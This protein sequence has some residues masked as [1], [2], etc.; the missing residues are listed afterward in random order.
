MALKAFIYDLTQNPLA[1]LLSIFISAIGFVAVFLALLL[2]MLDYQTDR[3]YPDYH[4]IYRLESHYTLPDGERVN[5]AQVPLPLAEALQHQSGVGTVSFAL[6]LTTSV[7]SEGRVISGVEIFAVSSEFLTRLNPFRQSLPSLAANEIVITP[8]FN[9]Q[10]LGL[11]APRGQVIELGGYGKFVISNVV[12]PRTDS[13]FIMPAIIAFSPALMSGHNDSKGAWYHN[14]VLAFIHGTTAKSDVNALLDQSIARYMPQL[15]GQPFNSGAFLHFRARNILDLH[16][17]TGLNDEFTLSV[18]RSLLNTLYAAAFFVLLITAVNFLSING[19]I[20]GAKRN[21]P[22]TMHCI[23]ASDLQIIIGYL[24]NLMP[25]LWCITAVA[26]VIFAGLALFSQDVGALLNAASCGL[27]VSIFGSATLIMWCIL[28]AIQTVY[29]RF[30]ILRADARRAYLRIE[31]STSFYINKLSLMIQLLISGAVV[32]LWA[33]VTTQNHY[34]MN[35]DFG[36]KKKNMLTFELNQQIHSLSILRGLQHRLKEIADDS[37]IALSGWRP[38]EPSRQVITVRHAGQKAADRLL[39]INTFAASP[40]FPAVWQLAFLAGQGNEINV[41]RDPAV[42]HVI[43]SRAFVNLLGQSSYD[44][45]LS[46]TFYTEAEGNRRVLRV[47]RIVDNFYPGERTQSPPPLMIFIEDK[48]EKYGSVSFASP[49]ERHRITSV[50][51]DY[52]IAEGQIRSVDE[53]HHQHFRNSLSML[54]LITMGAL[55]ALLLILTSAIIIGLSE[56]ARLR[57]TLIIM[58]AVGGSVVNGML[59][60]LRQHMAALALSSTLA[61]AAGFGFLQ[62]WLNQY[63]VVA[64]LTH[65]YAFAALA[66]LVFGVAVLMASALLAG[67]GRFP[68]TR[69]RQRWAPWT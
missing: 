53:L 13:S 21:A 52:G 30:F 65:T 58:E 12:E 35:A 62:E 25:Q 36:Y 59:F 63:D 67:G 47:L 42:A 5:S 8:A 38:F 54:R 31:T 27:L 48:L 9:R 69:C 6:R 20:H 18:A 7:R 49:R 16:Y 34:V 14:D 55:L 1:M 23:G 68:L 3:C 33:G 22:H 10:Y 2:F 60:F 37:T 32:Y 4:H 56:A 66:V 45:V 41:S 26:M 39:T 51:R 44:E 24:R 46:N 64:G 29:L 28:L 61:L 11:V 15:P 17:D 50:L 57:Y 40:E 19:V 43:V